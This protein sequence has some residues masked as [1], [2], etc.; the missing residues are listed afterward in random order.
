MTRVAPPI[1][2]KAVAAIFDSPCRPLRFETFSVP[3]PTPGEVIVRIRCAT[4][5]G[6]DLHTIAGRRTGPAPCVLGHEMIGEVAMLPSGG[7]AAF[8]G[9]PLHI[10]DRVTW[11]MLWTC[12]SCLPCLRGIHSSCVRLRKFGHERLGSAPQTLFGGFSEYCHLPA[13]TAVFRVPG[14][15][16]DLAAAP[17]NC[18]T[19]TVA[20]VIRHAGDLAGATVVVAGAGLL[21]L[22]ACAMADACGAERVILIE[23]NPARRDLAAR[24]GA[25]VTVDGL[26]PAADLAARVLEA[27]GRAGACQ[28][29]EFSGA[30]E[31]AA[32]ALEYL[33]PGGHL[34]LAGAVFPSPPVPVSAE[35]VVRHMLRVSGVYNY[36]PVDLERALEFLSREKEKFPFDE[37]ANAVFS[38]DE[39]NQAITFAERAKPPRVAI[40]P[41]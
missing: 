10:G 23:P 9:D 17:S 18:A 1:S 37:L 35:R 24:F 31:A 5:C 41:S 22:T 7:A 20:A 11:S 2:T 16:T 29:L 32:S 40:I 25:G 4:V 21:G 38:L 12:G 33:R 36:A 30:P 34:V 39:I 15:V 19:A 14:N 8:R 26:L 13:G 3:D 27:T 6:S 28:A